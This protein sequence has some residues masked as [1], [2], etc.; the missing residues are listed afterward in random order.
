[1]RLQPPLI[2][3]AGETVV[4]WLFEDELKMIEIVNNYAGPFVCSEC[5]TDFGCYEKLSAHL[6]ECTAKSNR[7]LQN[8]K[9]FLRVSI[10]RP[11]S[12]KRTE[13]YLPMDPDEFAKS[14]EFTV[15]IFDLKHNKVVKHKKMKYLDFINYAVKKSAMFRYFIWYQTE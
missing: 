13:Y 4:E 7:H 12:W 5:N 8:Q 14:Q 10:K 9:N 15:P 2:N 11:D 3:K 1:M 6:D